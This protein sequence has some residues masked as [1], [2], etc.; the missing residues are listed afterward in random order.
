MNRF[1]S[2][3]TFRQ[4]LRERLTVTARS[5]VA[6]ITLLTIGTLVANAQV[7]TITHSGPAPGAPGQICSGNAPQFSLAVTPPV[8]GT[9]AV[10]ALA[11]PVGLQAAAGNE[12]YIP[13]GAGQFTDEQV[14]EFQPGDIV[15]ATNGNDFTFTFFGTQKNLTDEG[16]FLGANGFLRFS[17]L[18]NNNV[19]VNNQGLVPQNIPDVAQPNDVI[20]FLHTDWNPQAGE[21]VW[22]EVQNIGGEDVFIVTF[23]NVSQY[24]DLGG[25]YP[26]AQS[27]V[28]LLIWADGGANAGRIETRVINW[29]DPVYNAANHQHTIGIENM[30]GNAAYA[31]NANHL[32]D[33]W[34]VANGVAE[35]ANVG[36][37][38]VPNGAVNQAWRARLVVTGADIA[39]DSWDMDAAAADDDLYRSAIAAGSPVAL[40]SNTNLNNGDAAGVRNFYALIEFDNCTYIRTNVV[41][42]TV[43]PSPSAQVIAGPTNV[44]SQAGNTFNVTATVPGSTFGGWTTSAGANASIVLA[45]NVS[46]NDQ[47]T[48]T[49]TDAAT[50]PNAVTAHT[51]SVTETTPAG[52]AVTSNK[53]VNVYLFPNRTITGGTS[54]MCAS[55]TSTVS[56]PAFSTTGSNLSSPTYA[57]SF[58]TPPP[59]GIS[60]TSTTGASTQIQ[61]TSAF[62]QGAPANLTLQVVVTN[63]GAAAPAPTSCSQTISTAVTIN[64]IPTAKTITS[65]DDS[66]CQA[67]PV[68]YTIN[69]PFAGN[70]Y[71]WSASGVAFAFTGPD[72]GYIAG[73]PVLNKTTA[74]ITW[75]AGGTGTVTVV[76]STPAGCLRTHTLTPIAVQALPTPSISGSNTPCTAVTPIIAPNNPTYQTTPNPYQYTYQ[77]NTPVL[78]NTYAWSLPLG[79]GAIIGSSS[80]TSIQVQWTGTGARSVSVTETSPAP[81]GC[82]ATQTLAVTVI[83]T[84]LPGDFGIAAAVGSVLLTPCAGTTQTLNTTGA[85]NHTFTLVGGTFIA[86]TTY[87]GTGTQRSGAGAG[88]LVITWGAGPSG[89]I[90]H[91]YEN[92]G[93]S[94]VETYNITINPLPTGTIDGPGPTCNATGVQYSIGNL[95]NGPLTTYAWSEISDVSNIA[96]FPGATNGATV[97]VDYTNI[98]PT[99]SATWTLGVQIT[100]SNGCVNNL[101]RVITVNMTPNPGIAAYVGP[102]NACGDDAN[103]ASAA[104]TSAYTFTGNGAAT[105]S[106]ALVGAPA[107]SSV[108]TL[109]ASGAGAR[110]FT[111]TWGNYIAP[112]NVAPTFT[113][114]NVNLT[115]ANGTC[116]GVAQTVVTNVYQVPSVPSINVPPLCANMTLPVNVNVT[117]NG[118]AGQPSVVYTWSATGGLT[119]SNLN[120]TG[121]TNTITA[122]G[123]AGNKTFT[124]VATGPNGCTNT[125]TQV[126]NVAPVPTPILAAVNLTACNETTDPAG[127][128][129]TGPFTFVYEYRVSNPTAG[130]SYSWSITNGYAVSTGNGAGNGGQNVLG[131][132][133]A[134]TAAAVDQNAVRVVWYGPT[135]GNV[136]VTQIHPGGCNATVDMDVTLNLLPTVQALSP[137]DQDI[138]AGDGA[139]I[140]QAASQVGFTYRLERS[141]D[142]GSTWSAVA[143][144]G[145][146]V[147]GAALVWNIPA[148]ALGYA[149]VPPAMTMYDFRIT[150]QNTVGA[151]T[152]GWYPATN[153][154]EVDVNPK[155]AAN[156]PV[157]TNP[158][159]LYICTG[160]LVK[161]LVGNNV[162]PSE[163]WV[164]YQ[165]QESP[166]GLNT[167]T[168]VG[169]PVVGDGI[170]SIE[171]STPAPAG[172]V[173]TLASD[174]YDY[175]VVATTDMS[176][177]PPPDISCQTVLTQQETARVFALPVD[178]GVT[179][180]NPVCWEE[181][182]TVNLANTQNG[183]QYEVNIGGFSLSPVV[184]ID[185]NGGSASAIINSTEF[186]AT[187]PV[188]LGSVNVN[189]VQVTARIAIYG[190]HVRPIPPSTCATN[191]G[192]TTLTV[193]EKPTASITG[194]AVV[195]GPSTTNYTAAPVTPSPIST[196]DWV[197]ESIPNA[198]P[199]GTTPLVQNNTGNGTVNPFIVNWG[200]NQ[201]SCDGSYNPLDVRIR[202]IATNNNACTDTAYHNV[203]INPTVSDATISGDPTACIYGGYEQHLETYTV[204][205]GSNCVFPAGTTYLWSVPAVGNPVSGAIRSGQG[206]TSIVAEWITTSG[207]GIG[208]VTCTITLP[209]SHGGCVTVR[210]FDVNVYPLPQPVVNGPVNVC[211]GQTGVV[212][213]ADAY[214]NDTYLWE[215][216]GGTIVGGTGAGIPGNLGTRTGIGL[217]TITIDWLNTANPNAYIRLTQ[218]S[219]AGCMNKTTFNV[220][221]HPTPV[222]VING[223]GVVCDN[224]VVQYSTANNAPNN[225]YTWTAVGAI[226]QSGAN[227]ATMSVLS[228]ASGSFTITLNE[229]VLATGCQTT[230][231]RTIN[232]VAKPQPTITRLNP[233]PGQV[234]GAC[235]GEEVEYGNTDPVPAVGG[236]SY[237]WTV[238]NGVI[239]T[240]TPSTGA[241]IKVTWNTVG[242]GTLTLAKWHTGSQCT[243]VVSQSVNISNKPQPAIAGPNSV[244]GGDQ[245]AYTTA[246][247]AGNTYNWSV[248]GATLVSG[249][250]SNSAIV[251]FP[252][253]A[254]LTP[255]NAT[256]SVTETNTLSGCFGS[257]SL[258]VAINYMPQATAI[259][260]PS[261][262]CNNATTN[263]SVTG[264]PAGLTFNWSVTGG[265]I[266]SGAGTSSINVEW[267]AVGNQTISLTMKNGITSCEKTITRV[268]TVEFQPAPS[269]SGDATVCTGEQ[270]AYSTPANA[271]S[272]YSWSVTGGTIVSGNSSPSIMVLWTTAGNQTVSVTETNASGNCLASRT[273]NVTVGQ[274]PVA[275]A[276]TRLSP[277]GNVSQACENDVITY[278]TNLSSGGTVTY[279]WT[280]TG[281]IFTSATNTATA[282]V[283]WTAQGNQTLKVKI[284]ASGTDCST[285]LTQNVTVTYKPAPNINGATVACINKDHVYQTPYVAGS[286][287]QWVITP[288]NVF[289]SITGYPNSNVIQVKWIQPGLHTVTVT[290][291]NIAGGCATTVSMNVQVNLIPTPFT[292]STTG[293]GNPAGLRPGIVCNFS[294]HTYTTVA[295]PGNTFIWT[296]TGGNITSG[297]YTNTINVTWGPSGTGTI[298]VQETIPGSDCIT[299]KLDTILIR[300]TPTPVITGTNFDPCA[301]TVQT[302]STPF[303]QGNSYYWDVPVGG[304]ILSGQNTNQITV[305]WDANTP[306]VTWPNTQA[307]QLRV[308]EWVTQVAPNAG[309]PSPY[310]AVTSCYGQTQRA[311]TIRPIPTTPV[312]SGPALVCASDLSD[313]PQTVNIYTYSSSVPAQGS[314]Q[315]FI[316][317]AWSTSGNGVIVGS[318][319][320]STVQIWWSNTGLTQTNGTIFLTH[321]SS[322]GCSS[323][324]T[325]GVTIN[326]LP[327]PVIEGPASVCQNSLQTYK[328][329]GVPGNT[330]SWAVTGGNIIRAGQN[331]PSVTVEWTLPGSYTLTV[332]ETNTFGCTVLNNRYV[333]VNALPEANITASGS[334]TF[335]QGGDVTL[336]APM[337][338]ASYVWSTGETARSI[339]VRTTG[340]YWVKI[341]DANGCSNNSDTITVNVF[342]NTLPIITVSGPTTFCEGG[343]VTLTA[344]SGFSAYLWSTGATTQSI[345]VTESGSYTVTIA[346]G[347]GCTGTSTEVDVFVNPKPAPILTVVGTTTICAGD[348]VEVRAP[349]GYVSYTWVSEQG[350]NYGTTRSIWVLQSDKIY[351]QVVDANGCVGESDT[352]QITV[353]PV[354]SPVIAA[355]GPTTFC[356]GNSVKLSAPD[357]FATYYWSN[358][359]TTREIVVADG[360]NY[361]VTVTNN[362]ACESVSAPTEV[363]VNPLPAR[364]GITRTG[365]TLKAVSNQAESFQ[366]FRNGVMIPGAVDRNLVVSLPGTYRVEIADNNTCSSKS[367]GFDVILTGVDEDVVAGHGAELRVFPNPTTGQFTV[368]TVMAEAGSVKIELVNTIGETVMTVNE[369]SNGGSFS[370]SVDMGTLATGVYNVVVTTNNERWT[371]RLV[372][373]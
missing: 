373:Q 242:T 269:I 324:S 259:N 355:N 32:N 235:F 351:V 217:N 139:T 131:T 311:V 362:A 268:V 345:T 265:A 166:I 61:V 113:P 42:I 188:G 65:N 272:T 220:V 249:N 192:T 165:L 267:S 160:E 12:V 202:M 74:Q 123:G 13:T 53:N 126:I 266:V 328:V 347:N 137:L 81:Y 342:P 323:S 319:T 230:V 307:T 78:G 86:P 301:G 234:G 132:V 21:N 48:I 369:F 294:S 27:T 182:V 76:E 264:E 7:A 4:Q 212:Y 279:E 280:T 189:N 310:G 3:T 133:S 196:F 313:D 346:D 273:L 2:A 149:A 104:P 183:V 57:W 1:D 134:I 227:Q 231:Q 343:S 181:N 28:Q 44:C 260:G 222:P 155:P 271:G 144:V 164:S 358:G 240:T 34:A 64:P 228:P 314:A 339:V 5:F 359:A 199:A 142:N 308:T 285:T 341:T 371:V 316:S 37:E 141:T 263:Y 241:T 114:V 254:N 89:T 99:A 66:P 239:N 214:P 248:A 357:G 312:I 24:E 258:L 29:A 84:P 171:L 143:G 274:T 106:V 292:T 190:S 173:P 278:G 208:T 100:N 338:Y 225:V 111:V 40:T 71:A 174:N 289:A 152:C 121:V 73:T 119:F 333:T 321:T 68:T 226:I 96:S 25:P 72:A 172:G 261:T 322:W 110:N 97:N 46:A 194:P 115:A 247:N 297:Q 303:V 255:G 284:T 331:T 187:N 213:T 238:S 20:Y 128:P 216:L 136:K 215:V 306:A 49:F 6:L 363:V 352:V 186:Q 209:L 11:G 256:I 180:T 287:Y 218:T 336:S 233:L 224:S 276:I 198:P 19:E 107:G 39:P 251:R 178:P 356:D 103:L 47:A 219:V 300:P 55:A 159:P 41:T 200:T 293:F 201:L 243:T 367:D 22:Y 82:S 87:P 281:G 59:T 334:T 157:V 163:N 350:V 10:A 162:T 23:D 232:V 262:V 206:T 195:C 108:T 130:H 125:L 223:P 332:T 50:A 26:H 120:P 18:I 296:V 79:G 75:S 250:T 370:A 167:W 326:P 244:C 177:A 45:T 315:G 94:A 257:T 138:C 176:F 325:Y 161:V 270:I 35:V 170:G 83:Q 36:W 288:S 184:I 43:N 372:R 330:Y 14:Y 124:V 145:T 58:T 185:G 168:N 150:A 169:T 320:G 153:M 116:V 98:W 105:Y 156:I 282:S 252:N 253:P 329:T 69:T 211:Q 207:T 118:N 365:D 67:Q 291:T 91:E 17:D 147:G 146:Q 349:A 286:S 8:V 80:G 309:L 327:N 298:A 122:L 85:G 304:T 360:G 38:F 302:Y 299:T 52:C 92:G 9:Y 33:T 361:T 30:C 317:Y 203:R 318:S 88:S 337:G 179:F 15:R 148:A 295:T 95:S 193:L 140:N 31:A 63:G 221:V 158:N 151:L 51:I 366:W 229:R 77:V 60:L 368:A 90:S 348:S 205:R 101:T 237:Q 54:S 277:A 129:G 335:C 127:K 93:C 283:R 154:V 305:R 353:A 210:T 102:A 117:N 340:Q 354:V 245:F 112:N 175:R 290:E 275:T 197:I 16:V 246:F 191:F 56:S 135:P 364:P 236:Y 62:T 204:A 70:S 344:P 109:P